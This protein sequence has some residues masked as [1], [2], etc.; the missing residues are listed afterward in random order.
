[1]WW[2]VKLSNVEDRSFS[3]L[4]L[5]LVDCVISETLSSNTGLVEISLSS[6]AGTEYRILELLGLEHRGQLHV[7]SLSPSSSNSDEV[8]PM[9]VLCIH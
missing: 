7:S 9:Q 5:V 2:P 6:A 4:V 1:M 3:E 8:S